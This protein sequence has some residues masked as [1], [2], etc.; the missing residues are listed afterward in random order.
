MAVANVPDRRDTYRLEDAGL[1]GSDVLPAAGTTTYG[2]EVSLSGLTAATGLI[3]AK[4]AH[5]ED[6]E[7]VL[8]LPPLPVADLKNTETLTFSLMGDATAVVDSGSTAIFAD[9]LVVTGATG[10]DIPADID[11]ARLKIPS[12]CAWPTIGL[13]CVAGAGTG[14]V[15]ALSMTLSLAF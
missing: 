12:D 13:R 5:L 2:A 8:A 1:K 11:A 14:D 7:A 3:T 9:F 4:G 15:S 6:A 10:V